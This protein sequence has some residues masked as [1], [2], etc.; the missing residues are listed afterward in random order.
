MAAAR[1]T[2]DLD[3][4]RLTHLDGT[5]LTVDEYDRIQRF[6][7]LWRKMGW[8][9]DETDKALIGLAAVPRGQ[10]RHP[11]IVAMLTS[12]PSTR[13]WWRN[14][15]QIVTGGTG[16]TDELRLSRYSSGALRDHA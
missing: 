14:K 13:V 6:I 3:K 11:A 8:T 2:C 4:V 16:Q 9:I 7:R 10:R 15:R 1:D 12:T 5:A